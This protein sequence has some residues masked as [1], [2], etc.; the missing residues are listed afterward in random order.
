MIITMVSGMLLATGS[1]C[2][3]PTEQDRINIAEALS[4]PT[5]AACY[6]KADAPLIMEFPRDA[7]SHDTFQTEWWY[8]TGN[9]KTS[10]GRDFGYQLTFFRQALSCEPVSGASKW[11]TQQL[12]FAHFAITDA[13]A[14]AFFSDLRMTRQ[15]IGLA[16]ARGNPYKVWID[17]W[18]AEQIDDHLTL[19]ARGEGM[20]L[21][22][23][24]SATKPILLQGNQGLSRKG[25]EP[26]NASYYYSLPRL[27]TRGTLAI[28][29][30]NHKVAGLSW[31]DHEWSTRAL[32]ADVAGWDWFSVH[33]DDG[34]DLMVCQVRGADG[35]PNGYAFGSLSFPD[36]RYEILSA[37]AFSIKTKGVW[38]SPATGRQ[39]P[40]QWEIRVPGQDLA[41]AVTPVI[42][43]QEHTHLFAYW[44][45]AAR[46]IGNGINGLGY[47]ELTGY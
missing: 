26:F 35:Q 7:G 20:T 17:D 2:S 22:L 1:G 37:D 32:D 6:E 42:Q 4:S 8:Y 15:S 43:N 16:G 46:F 11:R 14:N 5:T 9:L 23:V 34:R 18:R 12:Y 41:L 44:E 36:G 29:P 21:H 33:L 27:E 38:T 45:G 47:V 25:R 39:Y 10:Q 30:D 28:G 13:Q 40:G 31:F 3:P 19:T 24:L